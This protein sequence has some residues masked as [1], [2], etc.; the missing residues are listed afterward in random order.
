[1]SDETCENRLAKLFKSLR[2]RAKAAGAPFWK[3]TGIAAASVLALVLL[4]LYLQ[5]SIGGE[6]VAPG[7]VPVRPAAAPSGRTAVVERREIEDVLEW[8]GTVRSRTVAQVAAK[9]MARVLDV[10]AEVGLVVKTGE[11]RALLD[12]REVHAR[13]AQARSALEAAKAEAARA[14]ADYARVKG[15]FE[16]QAATQRDFEAAEARAKAA[17]AQVGQ[18]ENALR[19]AEVMLGETSIRAPFDGVVAEKFV[20]AGDTAVPGKPLFVIHDPA[21]L[22]L[23]AQVPESCAQKASV[24]MEVRTRIDALG[25]EVMARV[26]EISPVAD[27]QSRTFLLKATLPVDKDLRSGTFG[28]FL[29]PC[30]KKVELLIPA[31]AVTRSGQ[32][33]MVRVVEGAEV[34]SR[35]VRTG[36]THGDQVEVLSGLR[37][38]ETVLVSASN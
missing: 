38:G 22:R 7:N 12:D 23:E 21:R 1:M 4:L 25:R 24:G 29:Q 27:P 6:K 32:L 33:E 11:L 19:E 14:Q 28:R 36:K 16:K 10:K 15:L 31:A 37:E 20:Q 2:D 18:A 13:A 17:Q 5:G 9:L 3:K 8:P 30:G 26:E 35:H 34:R